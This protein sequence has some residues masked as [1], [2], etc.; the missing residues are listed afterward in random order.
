[1]W[2][3]RCNHHFARTL[4]HG[5]TLV[6]TAFPAFSGSFYPQILLRRLKI[7]KT[8]LTSIPQIPS[9]KHFAISSKYWTFAN[10]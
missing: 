1:M 5:R 3:V 8:D 10:D 2:S 6:F 4:K 7:F 9:E